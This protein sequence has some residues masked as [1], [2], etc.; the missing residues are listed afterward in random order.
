VERLAQVLSIPVGTA[1]SM[2]YKKR[3]LVGKEPDE[4]RAAVELLADVRPC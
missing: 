2:A 4:I 3:G 1:K